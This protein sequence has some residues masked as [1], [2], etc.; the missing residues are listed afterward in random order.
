MSGIGSRLKAVLALTWAVFAGVNCYLTFALPVM[1]LFPITSCG[2]VLR[3]STDCAPG[4]GEPLW[5]SLP[6]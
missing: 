6:S 3:C 5:S 4:H 1:K 2:Q